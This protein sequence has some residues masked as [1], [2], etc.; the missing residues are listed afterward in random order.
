MCSGVGGGSR[1]HSRNLMDRGYRQFHGTR[2]HSRRWARKQ[3]F[4]CIYSHSPSLTLLPE[5]HLLSSVRHL[6][7]PETIPPHPVS[8]AKKVGDHC[9]P[10]KLSNYRSHQPHMATEFLK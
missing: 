6:N 7:H 1:W 10:A 2:L 4:I 9:S 5:L 8:G 3:S